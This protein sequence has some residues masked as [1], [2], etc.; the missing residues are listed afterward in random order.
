MSTFKVINGVLH[1]RQID[2]PKLEMNVMSSLQQS[3]CAFLEKNVKECFEYLQSQLRTYPNLETLEIIPEVKNL[4]R[5][6][7]MKTQVNNGSYYYPVFCTF[8]LSGHVVGPV[9]KDGW[10]VLRIPYM[11]DYGHVNMDGKDKVILNVQRPSEGCSYTKDKEMFNLAFPHRNLQIYGNPKGVKAKYRGKM[12]DIA[13]ILMAM[14]YAAGDE[15]PLTELFTNTLLLS[16]LH[17]NPYTDYSQVYQHVLND[18]KNLVTAL[19]SADYS[20]GRARQSINK[21]ATL[22][23]GIGYELSRPVL[24]YPEHTKVTREVVRDLIKNRVN[25]Y[26][27]YCTDIPEGYC[28]AENTPIFIDY[29]PAGFPNGTLLRATFPQY[30]HY[31]KLPVELRTEDNPVMVIPPGRIIDKKYVEFLVAYGYKSLLVSAGKGKRAFRISFEREIIGNYTAALGD[32]VDVVPA[33]RYADEEVYYYNNPTLETVP[34]DNLTCHDLMA[35]VSIVGQSMLLGNSGLLDRD[36]AYLKKVLLIGDVFDEMLRKTI[37]DYVRR[38]HPSIERNLHP[39]NTSAK[40]PFVGLTKDWYKKFNEERVVAAADTLN[41]SAEVS[42]VNHVCTI[43]NANAEVTDEQ[44]HLATPFFSRICPYET[45]AGKKLGIV[46]TKSLGVRYNEGLGEVPVYRVHHMGGSVGVNTNQLYWLSQEDELKYKLGDIMSLKL[47]PGHVKGTY[48][49]ENTSILARVPNIS[50]DSEP[51]KFQ[52]IR[53]KDLAGHFVTAYPEQ[54]L[55]STAALIPF[56]CSNDPV[57]I[58]YGLSQLRQAIYNINSQ[59]PRVSTPMYE[60]ILKYSE[61]SKFFASAEGVVK[62]INNMR[63]EI[64]DSKGITHTVYMQGSC[65]MGQLDAT[66]DIYVKEGD[67]VQHG[68][69]LGEA[70]KYPQT[71]CVRA[72]YDGYITDIKDS[73]ITLSRKPFN[74]GGWVDLE[75]NDVDTISMS[76]YRITGQSVVLLSVHVSVGDYVKKGQILADTYASRGG[77]YSPSRNPLV[78]YLSTGYN[79]EDGVHA[80][81]QAAINYTSINTHNIKQTVNLLKFPHVRAHID[82]GFKYCGDGD[83]CMTIKCRKNGKDTIEDVKMS[84]RANH[85]AHGIPFEYRRENNTRT[86]CEYSV[87]LMG[88]NRLGEGDKMA[89]RHGNKGVVSKVSRDSE[90]PQLKNGRTLEFMLNPCGVPSRMNL[91]QIYDLHLGLVAEVTN[92]YI[93][94]EAFNSATPEDVAMML[95]YVYDLANTISIGDNFTKTYNRSAF[96]AVCRK[97]PELPQEYHELVWP[98]IERIIDWRGS[99]DRDGSAELYDPITDTFFDG[100]ITIG[101]P[102]FNKQEQ[103]ADEKINVRGG[104]LTEGYARN[105]GQPQKGENSAKGQRMGEMELVDLAAYGAASFL[106]E[107]LNEKSDNLGKRSANHLCQLGIEPDMAYIDTTARS[108]E[109]LIYYLE[110]VNANLDVSTDVADTS[111]VAS[112]TK[113]NLNVNRAIFNEADFYPH[114]QVSVARE[115]RSDFSDMGD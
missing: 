67:R 70:Y 85:K 55:S 12:V 33:G 111:R 23:R 82:S 71:F 46:N 81:M 30:A 86:S 107:V 97:Y 104:A 16:G 2:V 93:N 5:R 63:C 8:K 51:F 84:V 36:T 103:E 66:M 92:T 39:S 83:T 57:R 114:T 79:Y 1:I 89:G 20:L 65:H 29:L 95:S 60:D 24:N 64:V 13:N 96:D 40:N 58:S 50:D 9:S 87:N 110:V 61:T 102:M 101:F 6:D 19:A 98:N 72:P 27:V 77:V 31:D 47:H 28:L 94:V 62:S 112:V 113:S 43:T 44:R 38:C 80:T 3:Y 4:V 106:D 26:H 22:D 35:I 49:I 45:P 15:T 78:G 14:M 105:S 68:Q 76:N 34:H 54:F 37:D 91:G 74:A 108:V 42:Q 90:A 18:K 99:F 100:K 25:N 53:S 52:N 10:E 48:I 11:D 59:R 88:L 73:Y 17:I 115:Q 7:Y 69:L 75:G 56:A 41:L 21:I 32:L 109:N